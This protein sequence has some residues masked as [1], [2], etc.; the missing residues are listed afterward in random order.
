MARDVGHSLFRST[1][2]C[3]LWKPIL[4]K[5]RLLKSYRKGLE[6]EKWNY[7]FI[8]VYHKIEE[9]FFKKLDSNRVHCN[10]FAG[11]NLVTLA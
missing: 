6:K 9:I 2:Y 1:F 5:D 8:N 7:S 3:R 10:V 4:L 11:T